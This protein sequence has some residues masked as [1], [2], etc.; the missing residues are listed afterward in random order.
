M[1]HMSILDI[2]CAFLFFVTSCCHF[3]KPAS[4]GFSIK[5]LLVF[6]SLFISLIVFIHWYY[7]TWHTEIQTHGHWRHPVSDQKHRILKKEKSYR[8]ILDK[9][10]AAKFPRKGEKFWKNFSI[11]EY[12][13]HPKREASRRSIWRLRKLRIFDPITFR[14]DSDRRRPPDPV[15]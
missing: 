13:R 5:S 8:D 9:Y 10:L 2:Y 1:H 4:V 3:A 11:A 12:P 7:L 6:L 15:Q 14:G